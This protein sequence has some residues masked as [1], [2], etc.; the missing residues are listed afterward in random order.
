MDLD[1]YYKDH[2]ENVINTGL[3]GRFASHYHRLMEKDFQNQNFS[4]I[5]EVGAG[6]GQH[7]EYVQCSYDL[8]SQTDIRNIP[9]SSNK[10]L[11][12]TV[13]L[14][15]DAQALSEFQDDQFDRT[16]ATCLL[17]HLP[18][19]ERALKEWR[20]VTSK[21][22]GRISIY[23]PCEP[24]LLLRIGQRLSTRRKTRKLGI[25]YESMHYREH[26][27]HYYF[28]RTIIRDVFQEDIIKV[29]GFPTHRLPFDFKLY[30]IYQIEM[31]N[32]PRRS[33]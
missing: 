16:I 2:Y 5:L 23:I 21:K 10:V 14:Q 4:N 9:P 18:D 33:N 32:A 11:D 19:P 28:L 7:L 29:L 6:K 15:A 1:E 17:A 30:E 20:R 27:N 13:F 8:Y 3:I 26:R 12:K 24:S 31:L 22:G 25:N